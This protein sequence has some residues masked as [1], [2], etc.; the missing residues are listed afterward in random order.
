MTSRRIPPSGAIALIWAP[1][2]ADVATVSTEALTASF[3]W[4]DNEQLAQHDVQ[5]LNHILFAALEESLVGTAGANCLTDVY[6]GTLVNQIDC[7]VCDHVSDREEDFL[8]LCVSVKGFE[9]LED[10]LHTAYAQSE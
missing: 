7:D 1:A 5:E 9:R 4:M 6:H 3:G 10:S 8:D 2:P